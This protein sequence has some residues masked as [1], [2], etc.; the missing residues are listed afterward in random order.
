MT[1]TYGRTR[2]LQYVDLT[3]PKVAAGKKR[4]R[5]KSN[6]LMTGVKSKLKIHLQ[7]QDLVLF[8]FILSEYKTL[9]KL[10]FLKMYSLSRQG[11]KSA[12]VA[13]IKESHGSLNQK[14]MI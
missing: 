6:Q 3:A 8:P 4:V 9:K 1:H 14:V 11:I 12:I 10:I 5:V 13:T 2:I 7:N